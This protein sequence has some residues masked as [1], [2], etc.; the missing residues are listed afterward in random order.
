MRKKRIFLTAAVLAVP[1][2]IVG[3]AVLPSEAATAP[4]AGGTY[5]L[6]VKKSG[7]CIDVPAAS[8]DNGA[9]LQQWGCTEGAAWQQFKLVASGSNVL[10][11]NVGSGKCVDVPA[12]STVSGTQL[13]QWGCVGSQTNQQWKLAASGT[14]SYQIINVGNGLC[15]SDQAA[16]TASG[17]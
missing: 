4:V 5:T 7:K 17:A 8:K 10:L 14:D 16:S 9:L 12:S 15:I 13:Q 2:A 3:W 11:Q 1:A 6:A